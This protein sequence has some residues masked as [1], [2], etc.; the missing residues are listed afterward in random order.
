MSKTIGLILAIEDKCSPQLNKIAQ[1]L[2]L[3]EKE[4]KNLH[5]RVDKLAKQMNTGLK[6]AAK[7]AGVALG[8]MTA[9]SAALVTKTVEAGDRID[10]LSQKMQMSRKTFQELDYVFSQNGANIESMS[11]GI[12]KLSKNISD[13]SKGGNLSASIFERLGIS[14]TDSNGVLRKTEDVMFDVISAL[15][16][17]PDDAERATLATTLLGKSASELQPLLNRGAKNVEELRQRFKDLG[18]G[19]SDKTID[20]AVK[21]KDTMD[22]IGR[23]FSAV[24]FEIAGGLLPSLQQV[25]DSVIANMPQIKAVVVPVISAM[26]NGVQ[27]L[28]EHADV[29]LPVIGAVAG[30]FVAFNVISKVTVMIGF[31]TQAISVCSAAGGVLNAVLLANPIGLVVAGVGAAVAAFVVAYNKVEWFRKGVQ[32][33]W[34]VIKLFFSALVLGTK[35]IMEKIEPFVKFGLTIMSWVTPI[36]LVIRSLQ[37]LF[38]LLGKSGGVFDKVKSWAGKTQVE[39]DAKLKAPAK[40]PKHALGTM[41]APGGLSLVGEN[42]P[43]LVNLPQGSRVYNNAET[44][45]MMSKEITVNLNIGGNVVGNDDFIAQISN[46]LG[47]QLQTAL[48]V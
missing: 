34:S 33:T 4:A 42:G 40:V 6:N 14:V 11:K 8:A 32:A 9:V 37:A 45:N 30:G 7:T 44:K 5:N 24:G 36:G 39:V 21:F 48:A 47:R 25:S 18:L 10:K 35:I 3:T 29:L 17:L 28:I 12:V 23:S 1:R 31:F 43:E 15:Q 26:L 2:G 38:S 41:S 27:S 16:K 46:V 13:A 20:S 22:T 19:M